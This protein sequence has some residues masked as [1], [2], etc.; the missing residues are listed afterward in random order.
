MLTTETISVPRV[1]VVISGIKGG[2]DG[3][4]K[5]EGEARFKHWR[6]R[7]ALA[8]ASTKLGQSTADSR[9]L[10]RRDED[11]RFYVSAGGLEA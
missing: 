2:G 4:Q 3:G 11:E 1:C 5:Q 10:L 8:G 7:E 6:G 9:S